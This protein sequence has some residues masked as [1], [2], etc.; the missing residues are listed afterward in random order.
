MK[1]L[2]FSLAAI[3]TIVL[4]I[5]LNSTLVL[6]A[7]LG[8]LL[9][10]QHGIWQNAEPVDKDFSKALHFAGLKGNVNVY[11]DDRLVPH[12]FA[13]QENDAW[14][15][16]GYLHAKF[17]LWQMELQTLAAAGRASEIIG[18]KAL[19]HD[20][21][22]RRL[23]MV[24]AAE[25]SLEAMEQDPATK[26]Q[27]DSYTAGVNAYIANLSE[28]ELPFEYKLIGYK[29]E[30]WTNFKTALFLKYMS[31]D[32][33]G[34]EEDFEMTN[35]KNQFSG[36]DFDLL[37]PLQSDSTEPI[38]PKGTV[39]SSPKFNVIRPAT[40]DSLYYKD[41]S[42]INI[43][44]SKP[45]KENGSNNWAVSG[46]KTLSGAPILCNDPHLGLNLPSIWY[47]MQ[48]V[49]PEFSVY[50]ATF[51]GASS[52]IIGF[53]ENC[54][55]GFTNGGRDVRDYYEIKFKNKSR[56]EYW[57]NGQWQPATL[58][59]E[60]I[61]IKNEVPYFDTV[62]YTVFGP[63]MFDPTFY[64]D[65]FVSNKSYAVKWSAHDASNDLKCFSL[66]DRAKNYD[67]YKSA[68]NFLLTPAQ[69]CAF[70]SKDG[71]I[72]IQ[73]QGR[74]PAKWKR[75]GDFI[76]P[77][78]DSSYM[79]Q[80]FI[81][82]D[83][84]PYQYNPERGFISSANQVPADTSYPY[85]LGSDY[86]MARGYLINKK[87]SAMNDISIKDMMA[88]QTNTEDAF[89]KMAMPLVIKYISEKELEKAPGKYLQILKAWNFH[90]D[91]T[92]TGATVFN[93]FWDTFEKEVWLDDLEK[94][95]G[96]K[97]MP[98]KTTLLENLLKDSAFKFIDNSH[99]SEFE[100][101][102]DI[103]TSSFNIASDSL[104]KIEAAGK[105]KWSDYRATHIDHLTKLPAL[106]RSGIISGGGPLTI[107]ALKETHGPSWR[108]I[109]SLTQK[110]EAYG[111]YPGGQSGNPGSR[112]YDNFIDRWAD[113]KYYPLW[114]MTA[115]EGQ[116]KRVKWTMTFSGS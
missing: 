113:G 27:C 13:E 77:G 56:K 49:T 82:Q 94:I 110:I 100:T 35:A 31:Y 106:N 60:K 19:D 33:A 107:N 57:F 44:A 83:E 5:I 50:G 69:N 115:G 24:Y 66:L 114:L 21:E 8:K 87:L 17:R 54:A 4:I 89:A 78:F 84:T 52:V 53:N 29:P 91:A 68:V 67:D 15:V 102:P 116:D 14:F 104:Q 23:G 10:P 61:A 108:M 36:K 72:A 45:D 71:D 32:L 41:S 103:L 59:I 20:R 55:F 30:K 99:T 58:R 6:P 16:Q 37:Y 25:N 111:V 39:Y 64:K 34:H 105:L 90:D 81:P 47:E 80:D 73:T 96:V 26:N 42:A 3:V 98:S 74:F 51:P 40:A 70:A 88:L 28:S 97:S 2:A 112:F 86:P 1:I 43:S 109:V 22:F 18:S 92:S 9:S 95:K 62:A 75:Q 48:I 76:M 63:V 79:W 65:S 38:I 12:V 101:L 46:S 85:Y 11:F 7:P 93:V